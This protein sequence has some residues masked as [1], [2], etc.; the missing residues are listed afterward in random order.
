[1]GASSA[2]KIAR[3]LLA[4]TALAV[5]L[6]VVAGTAGARA[7][8]GKSGSVYSLTNAAAGNAVLVFDRAADGT[9]TAVG[10]VPT[11]GLGTGAG[12]GSQNALVLSENGRRLF[13]V[14]AGDNTISGFKVTNSGLDQIGGPVSSGGV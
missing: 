4:A 2:S 3:L 1:M 9:L 8:G 7:V 13:A 14:N 6:A 12:L 10:T 5:A 11:G